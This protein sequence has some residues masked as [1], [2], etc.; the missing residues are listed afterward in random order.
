[1]R[2]AFRSPSLLSV[3]ALGSLGLIGCAAEGSDTFSG[4]ADRQTTVNPLNV[5][6]DRYA[7]LLRVFAVNPNNPANGVGDGAIQVNWLE[8]EEPVTQISATISNALSGNVSE[9][10]TAEEL[11]NCDVFEGNAQDWTC[12]TL[13]PF[14]ADDELNPMVFFRMSNVVFGGNGLPSPFFV[15]VGVTTPEALARGNARDGWAKDFAPET[16]MVS[17]GTGDFYVNSGIIPENIPVQPDTHQW[18]VNHDQRFVL[19]LDWTNA[20]DGGAVNGV[21]LRAHGILAGAISGAIIPLSPPTAV[22]QVS[23]VGNNWQ[24]IFC[25]HSV[26]GQAF[27][28]AVRL[29]VQP[30]A[31]TGT[32]LDF[33]ASFEYRNTNLVVFNNAANQIH[34]NRPALPTPTPT[35]TPTNT[36]TPT[37]TPSP[38]VPPTMTPTPS[39]TPPPTSTPTPTP[40]PGAKSV[41]YIPA[42][43]AP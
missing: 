43:F 4:N 34:V 42:V 41:V 25:Y 16:P 18:W 17:V 21:R 23:D 30:D 6:V 15:D 28:A 37:A 33:T 12:R 7:S 19:K 8:P 35:L 3:F 14:S 39:S 20:F 40:P 24:E 27:P 9:F 5:T 29:E 36:P 11:K 31:S 32:V 2:F 26:A 38:T 22:C 13:N 10:Y 1:M